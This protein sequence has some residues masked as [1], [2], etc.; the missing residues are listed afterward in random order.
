VACLS[1]EPPGSYAVAGVKVDRRG[2][3]SVLVWSGRRIVLFRQGPRTWKALPV[4][5][6]GIFGAPGLT[7]DR[8]GL[9]AVAYTL[10][11][12]PSDTYLRLVTIGRGGRLVS[13][14]I[15]RNGFPASLGPPA[16]APVLVG[17]RLHVVQG[18]GGTV[19]DW[20]PTGRTWEG[21]FLFATRSGAVSGPVGGHFARGTLHAALT[22]DVPQAGELNVVHLTSRTTQQ[23]AVVFRH[24][25]FVSLTV[26]R[27]GPE[28]AAY[29]FAQLSSGIV[30]AGLVA[31]PGLDVEIDGRIDGYAAIA[32]GSRYILLNHSPGLE[33]YAVP[34]LLPVAVK[35]EARQ[36][37][38][39]TTSLTGTVAGQGRGEVVLY[40]EAPGQRT[41][42]GR[43]PLSADGA[44]ALVDPAP[45]Q[46]TAYRAVYH[47]TTTGLPYAA[48]L[49]TPCCA[50]PLR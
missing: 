28:V 39:G 40:R 24:A 45:Q 11:R 9:P 41:L 3:A 19:V 44:F 16:A 6:P 13:T 14:P 37:P 4:A 18:Y 21:Q 15:T 31:T 1:P 33:F 27:T 35:L 12:A 32:E 46:D 23:S 48:L 17:R 49:R 20:G 30:Y 2:L 42:I 8:R 38:D 47:E 43:V 36:E 10:W 7:L 26:P 5:H 50:S 22:L 29:D 25:R 34:A